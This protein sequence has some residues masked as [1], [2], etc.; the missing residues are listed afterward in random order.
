MPRRILMLT[1]A[2]APDQTGGLERYVRELSAALVGL[3]LGVEILAKRVHAG[4]AAREMGEDGVGIRRYR[5]ASRSRVS[6]APTYAPITAA[7][8][9]RAVWRSPGSVLHAHFPVPAVPLALA[10]RTYLYTFHA[11]VHRELLSER[12]DSYPLATA[13][14]PI[15]VAGLRR[16]ERLVVRRAAGVVVLSEFARSELGLLDPGAA[17]RAIL[18]PGGIDAGVFAPGAATRDAWARAADPLLFTA[19]RLTPRTG[20]SELLEAMPTVLRDL[21]RARLQIAGG[22]RSEAALRARAS[23]LGLDGAVR[24]LGRV[25]EP[26]LVASYR[27]ADLMIMPSQA[28]EGFGLATAEALACGTPVVGTPVGATPELLAGI[29]SALVAR[30]ASPAGIASAVTA[31]FAEPARLA[32]VRRRLRDRTAG[33]GWDRVAPRYIEEYDRLVPRGSQ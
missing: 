10:G 16:A 12:H 6:F 33:L 23:G 17:E 5:L 2:I 11:P 25:G 32:S 18:I 24:F 20:V 26:E 21:P 29:D 30:D 22:G 1:N 9:G 13:V 14:A 31:L 3:G 27:T 28:L 19:R 7:A 15:A 8:V 4:D